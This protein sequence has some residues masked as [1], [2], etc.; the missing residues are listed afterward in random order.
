MMTNLRFGQTNYGKLTHRLEKAGNASIELFKESLGENLG[1]IR[2]NISN[3]A[4]SNRQFVQDLLDSY[5]R[6]GNFT[7]AQWPYIV[8]AWLYLN[9]NEGKGLDDRIETQV[10]VLAPGNSRGKPVYL[11]KILNKLFHEHLLADSSRLP[12]I[13][14]PHDITT[15]FGVH[16]FIITA[17]IDWTIYFYAIDIK[18]GDRRIL[19][20]MVPANNEIEWSNYAL[21]NKPL[22]DWIMNTFASGDVEK[23]IEL[24]GGIR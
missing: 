20:M 17:R 3:I 10:E 15:S 12:K 13:E 7:Y 18:L 19:G 1:Y 21:A 24:M 14:P 23:K 9:Q 6:Y 8:A 16:S 2:E 22:I 4:I 11:A 5:D